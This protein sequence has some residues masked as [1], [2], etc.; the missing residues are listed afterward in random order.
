MEKRDLRLSFLRLR[1]RAFRFFSPNFYPHYPYWWQHLTWRWLRERQLRQGFDSLPEG[2]HRRMV[3]SRLEPLGLLVTSS[4]VHGALFEGRPDIGKYASQELR[5][6]EN[7]QRLGA[8]IRWRHPRLPEMAIASPRQV[9]HWL[10]R[11]DPQL[12]VFTHP[13]L[14]TGVS[15]AGLVRVWRLWKRFRLNGVRT[16]IVWWDA[17]DEQFA[18]A[19]SL[20]GGSDTAILALGSTSATV[21]AMGV[22]AASFGPALE[23]VLV[24]EDIAALSLPGEWRERPFDAFV[25]LL[26]HPDGEDQTRRFLLRARELGMAVRTNE[27]IASWA[28]Y[29][30]ALRS[31]RFSLV[32]NTIRE[33]Y[34]RYLKDDPT[35]SRYHVVGRNFDSV[36]AGCVLVSQDCAEIRSIF[37]A[38]QECLVWSSP[39]EAAGFIHSTLMSA[40]AGEAMRSRA[41]AR[42]RRL[43]DDQP[44]LTAALS[45]LR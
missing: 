26:R 43:V 18:A 30:A 37:S 27:G 5:L 9:G 14:F 25:P 2:Q 4:A 3:S 39:E 7:I 31:C 16:L 17:V 21:R 41:H 19:T 8:D 6:A 23:A 12:V 13:G 38:G 34:I 11:W 24:P 40:A 44:G 35:I 45:L 10:D 15:P 29:L 36:V 42:V 22:A 28:E 1:H 32:S 33:N 20:T